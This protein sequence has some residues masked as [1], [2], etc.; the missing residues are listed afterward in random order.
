MWAG[1]INSQDIAGVYTSVFFPIDF[2]FLSEPS[3]EYF[4][5][6]K[7]IMAKL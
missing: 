7:N 5:N 2:C 1:L 6:F 3:M 4:T